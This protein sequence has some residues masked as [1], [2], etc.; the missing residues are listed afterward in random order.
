MTERRP[1][2]VIL[3]D[4]TEGETLRV[5]RARFPEA[6]LILLT[7]PGAASCLSGL[8]DETWTDGAARGPARFLALVRRLSWAHIG[9]GYDCENTA[10][11]RFIR[12]C[13]WPR[14]HW[15][16]KRYGV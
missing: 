3:F 7:V 5:L 10:L 13:V 16:V 4:P 2:L 15:H 1:V 11:T 8:A 14:P 12:L 9:E 6:R